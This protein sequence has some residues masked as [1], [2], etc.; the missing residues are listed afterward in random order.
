[1]SELR[2]LAELGWQLERAIERQS[3]PVAARP[4]RIAATV[5]A[6][7]VLVTGAVA[8]GAALLPLGSPVRGP[9]RA[10]VPPRLA[11]APGSAV[12]TPIRVADPYGGDPWGLRV[13]RSAGGGTCVAA[14]RVR[15][16]RLGRIGA[17][18]Q[19][20]ELPM[21]GT[22]SCA[23]PRTDPVVFDV[24][25]VRDPRRRVTV[26]SGSGDG[27]ASVSISGAA[28]V[29]RAGPAFLA[30]LRGERTTTLRVVAR[31]KDGTRRTLYEP[32]GA[33]PK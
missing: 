3:M 27:V 9:D 14:G 21:V 4:R 23:D 16:G 18:G 10:D 33:K 25:V 22:G 1:M 7:A 6:A 30:V 15:D 24:A 32:R 31:F 5:A 17:D 12:L 28:H 26:V 8:A 19:F 11:P 2:V 20:H 13:A 29:A